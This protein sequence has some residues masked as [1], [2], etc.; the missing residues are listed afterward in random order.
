MPTPFLIRLSRVLRLVLHV[1]A[2]LALVGFV[3]PL[4]RPD[5]RTWIASRWSFRLLRILNV[6]LSIRRRGLPA[7]Q[8]V[9]YAAN[10][11]S[12]IDIVA[13]KA[14]VPARFVAKSEIRRWPVFGWLARR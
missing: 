9:L 1:T 8:P 14:V 6:R 7:A 5:R 10:H 13:L 12:W 11:I 4:V 3:F 2:G